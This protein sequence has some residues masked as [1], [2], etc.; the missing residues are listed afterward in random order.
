MVRPQDSQSP[1][2]FR[3][4]EST[5]SELA[6]LFQRFRDWSPQSVVWMTLF[7]T[8]PDVRSS[9]YICLSKFGSLLRRKR[10]RSDCGSKSGWSAARKKVSAS[11]FRDVFQR[12]VGLIQPLLRCTVWKK[13]ADYRF[14]A[15]DATSL[16]TPHTQETTERFDRP[17]WKKHEYAHF[18]RALLVVAYDVMCRLPL[19]W[20]LLPKGA[21]ERAALPQFISQFGRTD[22]LIMDRGY[23]S[24]WLL[25]EF[26]RSGVKVVMRMTVKSGSCWKEVRTFLRSRQRS[27]IITIIDDQGKEQRARLV[28]RPGIRGRPKNGKKAD[29]MVIMTNL[30]PE[31]G[32]TD[33]DIIQIYGK[34]WGIETIFRE[35]KV[36]FFIERFHARNVLGIEQEITAIMIWLAI[37]A[38]FTAQQMPHL[39]KEHQANRAVVLAHIRDIISDEIKQQKSHY[40]SRLKA[41][42]KNSY[43]PQPGRHFERRT[44]SNIGRTKVKNRS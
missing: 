7:L 19:D 34:R 40:R 29:K 41:A 4:L 26:L 23:P 13:Y 33:D 39:A 14:I 10:S 3:H 5:I 20:V 24:H 43:K 32:F 16:I 35:I 31:D 11:V 25:H 17:K 27:A 21:G 36:N 38:V 1:V 6:L 18:P 8:Q 12:Y 30:M 28:R 22:V 42:A 9:Y 44:K 37:A 15:V 2:I